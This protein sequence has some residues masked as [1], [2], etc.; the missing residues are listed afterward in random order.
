M[1]SRVIGAIGIIGN[2]RLIRRFEMIGITGMTGISQPPA[3]LNQFI[4]INYKDPKYLVKFS[5]T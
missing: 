2:T 5:S 1:I 4:L 3:K